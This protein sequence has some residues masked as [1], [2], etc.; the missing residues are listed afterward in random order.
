MKA[1]LKAIDHCEHE[2]LQVLQDLTNCKDEQTQHF[3]QTR[4]K[5]LAE[6][7]AMSYLTYGRELEGEN[8]VEESIDVYSKGLKALENVPETSQ[9]LYSQIGK[10]RS[11]AIMKRIENLEKMKNRQPK[12]NES[13]L[14]YFAKASEGGL[15]SGSQ[16]NIGRS[17]RISKQSQP[18]YTGKLSSQSE[19]QYGEAS[20][21]N[22]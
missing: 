4:R 9:R 17:V 16:L 5:E 7:L 12:L 19:F 2:I 6:R 14:D 10:L 22:R 18:A 20:K 1:S 15:I 3:F 13:D 11:M 21:A 8:R